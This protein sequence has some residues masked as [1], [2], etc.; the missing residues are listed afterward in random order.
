[1]GA[2]EAWAGTVASALI[3]LISVCLVLLSGALRNGHAIGGAI[4]AMKAALTDEPPSRRALLS[5]VAGTLVPR[6]HARALTGLRIPVP[7]GLPGRMYH[8]E[9]SAQ[10]R[11]PA[12]FRVWHR[13]AVSRRT[14]SAR[15]AVHHRIGADRSPIA[16]GASLEAGPRLHASLIVHRLSAKTDGKPRLTEMSFVQRKNDLLAI[17]GPSGAGKTSLFSALVGEL[18]LEDGE[19]YLGELP[20]RTHGGQ[21]REKLGF[22]PQDEHLFR[23]FT[24][25]KLLRYSFELRSAISKA[26]RDQRVVEVCEQLDIGEQ[27]DQLIGTLSGGQRK[28]VSIAVELLNEPMLLMLDEPTSGL[29]AGMDREV[30]E[31]LQ[32]YAA[33]DKTVIVITHS[34]EHLWLADRVL[35]V[36]SGGR[37]VYFG[38]ADGVL[39]ELGATTYAELM[40]K[41]ISDP[42]PAATAYQNGPAVIEAVEEAE[43]IAQ[44]TPYR[45]GSFTVRRD[46]VVT[47][48]RQLWVLIR[49]QIALI[50][51]RGSLNRS[52]RHHPVRRLG[53]S[54][55][56][57]GP[58][59]IAGG[60]AAIAGLVS[61][62]YGLGPGHG[63]HGST[64]AASALSLLITLCMLTGQA[65]TYSDI[66]NDYPIIRREHR[67]GTFTLPVITAKW[68]VFALVAV[69]QALLI[70]S[71]Y[72]WLRPG[73][74]YSVGLGSV[75]ELF[76]DLAAVTV[77]AMTLGL[78]ISAALPKL[79]QAIAVVTGVSIAQIALNGV[80]SNLSGNVGM[81]IASMVLPSRWGLAA[82]AASIDLRR[83]SPTA[84][85]DALWH[86]SVS[87]WTLDL[88]MLGA[89][90]GAYFLLSGW[91]LS[92]RLNKPDK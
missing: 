32:K 39:K 23:T 77:A 35:V 13:P 70:T 5:R 88:A 78:L 79:E 89:L 4:K 20:L 50:L 72:L 83:I 11:I 73:P 21:I 42:G 46:L 2:T 7:A 54:L 85:P 36:A 14:A 34:T 90:T 75:A 69:L 10:D 66:V 80:A 91:L 56:V 30:L 24:V 19:L 74:A 68:L 41:L 16:D 1:M 87:Q 76:T 27:L 38:S 53:G 67:T 51:T 82:T 28:R 44:V 59:L 9:S 55:T 71:V 25:R 8:Q 52:D 15:Q 49:R 17:L 18:K 45:G 84:N 47:G 60:G 62:R 43:R 81:N 37:P 58:L 48:L 26:S 86:H 12:A 64:S 57:L 40:R 3:L 63:V 61:G 6:E 29:D 92:R 65:L 33:S 22:V 31:C